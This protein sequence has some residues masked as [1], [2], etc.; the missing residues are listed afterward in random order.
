MLK[1]LTIHTGLSTQP[2]CRWLLLFYGKFDW[3]IPE[4]TSYTADCYITWCCEAWSG[5]PSISYW[6]LGGVTWSY[7]L[8]IQK[9]REGMISIFVSLSLVE[10]CGGLRFANPP[11]EGLCPLGKSAVWGL[12]LK[13]WK[14]VSKILGSFLQLFFCH[15]ASPQS[16][17]FNS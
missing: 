5:T 10:T 8:Y 11:Y 15:F 3:A 17:F 14:S 6:W 1:D 12:E 4:S 9:T 16:S 2:H 7:A 13:I